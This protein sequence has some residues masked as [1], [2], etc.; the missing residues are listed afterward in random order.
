MGCWQL[1]SGNS[2]RIR[3]SHKPNFSK[4]LEDRLDELEDKI[5]ILIAKVN[6]L[7]TKLGK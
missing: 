3:I 7:I 1:S 2:K 4:N 6:E 5:D